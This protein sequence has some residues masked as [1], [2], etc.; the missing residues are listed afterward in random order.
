MDINKNRK[1]ILNKIGALIESSS[2][3]GHLTEYEN[4]QILRRV[5]KLEKNS[6]EEVLN[7]QGTLEKGTDKKKSRI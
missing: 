3:Y 2:Y 7:Y 1:D 4:L 6:I 5:L